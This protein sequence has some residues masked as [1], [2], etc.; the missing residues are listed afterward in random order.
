MKISIAL[1]SSYTLKNVE[2][3]LKKELLARGFEPEFSHGGY[4]QFIQELIDTSSW[5]HASKP[6]VILIALSA[7][8]FLH[9]AEYELLDSEK[10]AFSQADEKL[11]MLE[12]ALLAIDFPARVILT[13]LDFPQY[14]PLGVMDLT[15]RGM[16]SLIEHCNHRLIELAKASDRVVLLDFEKVVSYVGKHKV[17]DEKLF[18]MGKLVLGKEAANAF[19]QECATL[20]NASYGK[21]KKCLVVDLDNTLWGG[22]VGEDGKNSLKIGKEGAGAIY[23]EIQLI[24]RNLKKKG[25]LLA[26][27]SKNNL[28]DAEEAFK[29]SEMVL[30]LDD[31]V[32]RRINWEH[33]SKNIREIAE[34][35]SLGVDSF[36]FLDDNIAERMEVK[37]NVPEVEVIDFP[38]DVALLPKTLQQWPSFETLALTEEDKKR[39][40]LYAEERKRETLKKTVS[41]DDYLKQLE[42]VITVKK[43]DL[44]HL[45]RITQLTNKTNQFNLTT[46]RYTKEEMLAFMQNKDSFVTSV[47]VR[48][49]FGDLGLTG[50]MIVK[51]I[52]AGRFLIDSFLMSC[53]ILSRKIENQ[54]FTESMRMISEKDAVVECLYVPTAKNGL[55]KEMYETLG[56]TLAS[57]KDG[58]KEYNTPVKSLIQNNYPWIRVE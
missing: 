12:Q 11:G 6:N 37:T 15:S 32:A 1:L 34:E 47:D 43:N 42:I 51:R 21:T 14:S 3:P 8:T 4:N 49:K 55:V 28:E 24:L 16:H 5:L 17:T 19:A 53:R 58:R 30:K 23:R 31:F 25:V 46:K 7:R 39:H 9:E 57:E 44:E 2:E 41:L 18:Y 40:D 52:S 10:K 35:L 56:C 48:D 36:A 33:K 50:V 26:I 13:T 27:A 45:E 54:Y 20:I 22:V 29:N 38:S